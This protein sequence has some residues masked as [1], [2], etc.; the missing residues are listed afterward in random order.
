[1]SAKENNPIYIM[2]QIIEDHFPSIA[3]GWANY[4]VNK[5]ID[6]LNAKGFDITKIEVPD[7]TDENFIKTIKQLTSDTPLTE[8]QL[9]EV[10]QNS[11]IR[12]AKVKRD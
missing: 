7:L 8:D 5:M 2:E 6:E 9:N 10:Y 12:R 1:M 4:V 11:V 3:K